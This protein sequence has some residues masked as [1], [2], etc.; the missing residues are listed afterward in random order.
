M[1]ED[2]SL[3]IDKSKI[4][5]TGKTCAKIGVSKE[6][7]IKQRDYCSPRVSCIE[8]QVKDLLSTAKLSVTV[9]NSR[10]TGNVDERK[11]TRQGVAA[12]SLEI[13]LPAKGY[14]IT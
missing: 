8:N 5:Y 6:T 7:I 1:L 4:D 11:L 3:M 12:N 13:Y 9:P 10:L 2:K 14:S